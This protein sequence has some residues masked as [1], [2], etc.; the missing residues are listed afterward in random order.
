VKADDYWVR[1][2]IQAVGLFTRVE[3]VR[4]PDGVD[5]TTATPYV[6]I[7]P[8]DGRDEQHRM[9]GPSGLM[10]PR[11]TVINVGTSYA[12]VKDQ[13]ALIKAQFHTDGFGVIPDI[14]GR[15]SLR[16]WW[17]AVGAIQTDEDV[18]PARFF[19]VAECG[20]PTQLSS[21]P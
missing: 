14:P 9:T 8:S 17:N 2:R 19:H 10:N 3:F 20:Y 18:T 6:I 16:V 12:E 7:H 21:Q 5:W 15:K 4:L 1:S 11:F 13:A